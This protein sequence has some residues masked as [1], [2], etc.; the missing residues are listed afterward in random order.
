MRMNDGV[1]RMSISSDVL[2]EALVEIAEIV[3]YWW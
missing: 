2:N 3:E 1:E